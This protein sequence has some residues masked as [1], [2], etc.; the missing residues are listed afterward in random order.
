MRRVDTREAGRRGGKRR[1]ANMTA[2]QRSKAASLA[3]SVRWAGLTP[4]Q[5][6]ALASKAAKARWA[7]AK[8]RKPKK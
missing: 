3:V 5:R 8:K 2:E 1:A 6:S 4:E 7:K